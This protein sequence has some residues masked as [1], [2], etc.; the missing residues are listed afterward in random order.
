MSLVDT[1][2]RSVDGTLLNAATVIVG[3]VLGLLIGN[4]LPRRV[5]DT[6]FGAIGLVTLLIGI[7]GALTTRNPLIILGSMLLGGLL[8]ELLRLEDGLQRL[9]D[10]IERRTA[11][12]G[13]SVSAAFVTSSLVFC[14][15]PLSILGPLANGLSGDISDLAIKAMLDGFGA[16]AF[17]A[18]LGWGVFFSVLTILLYQG[19]ISLAAQAVKPLVDA[20]P[21]AL[22]ELNAVGGVI[23][24]ALGLKLLKIR[25]LRVA[26]YL[27]ALLVAPL[28]AVLV[29][30]PPIHL[31]LPH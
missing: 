29:A 30:H 22:V 7:S 9:G 24:I 14:V 12:Q 17:A 11:R 13:S 31:P 1:M 21:G 18:T 4:R 25:D 10:A 5:Q 28:L 8:G 2:F 20:N 23:L 19:G 16:I 6:L 15:G 27:P 26:N 3:T